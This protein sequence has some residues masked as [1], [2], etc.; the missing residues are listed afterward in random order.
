VQSCP[1]RSKPPLADIS[2]GTDSFPARRRRYGDTH[3]GENLRG[4]R[5]TPTDRE[6]P[7]TG[8]YGMPGR[9]GAK[10]R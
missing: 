2:A 1:G 3:L 4:H 10:P 9:A 7:N 6:P 5:L 8:D